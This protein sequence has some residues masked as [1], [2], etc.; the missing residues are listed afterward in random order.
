MAYNN[1]Q[2]AHVWASGSKA[3]GK[4]NNGN[5]YFD[6][7]VLYSYGSH[8]AVGVRMND[9]QAV[10]N[11]DSYSISTSGMQSDA[12]NA[13]SHFATVYVP[14]L[15]DIARDLSYIANNG[16]KSSARQVA[17]VIAHIETHAAAMNVKAGS[18]RWQE[19]AA[20]DGEETRADRLLRFCGIPKARAA[21]A[22]K[23]GVAKASRDAKAS[24]A[25]QRKAA[26]AEAAEVGSMNAGE[27]DSWLQKR[28]HIRPFDGTYGDAST[29][30]R[31]G[32]ASKAVFRLQKVAK[33][34]GLSAARLG[35][36]KAHRAAVLAVLKAYAED[37]AGM[38]A[39]YHAQ[40]F[41]NWAARMAEAKDDAAKLAVWRS[42]GVHAS[43]YGVDTPERAQ[44][45]AFDTW[46]RTEANRVK[47][48]E[49]REARE[50]WQRGEGRARVSGPDGSALV[51]RSKDGDTLETSHGAEV[52]WDHA[53][54]AFR[55]IALC[56]AKGEGFQ[57]NGRTVR[58][59]HFK[60]DSIAP[61]GDMRAGC[62]RFA[63]EAMRALAEREGVLALSPSDEAV[64]VS[65]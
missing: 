60:V 27:F 10:L 34:E 30:E 17:A 12:S 51:R 63:W 57:T 8:F 42:N 9:N 53:V 28:F 5:F 11:S 31:Y 49:E 6:A 43:A 33:A 61:N 36:L 1:S 40:R 46:G 25:K 19:E 59:G 62:H 44:L 47:Y 65:H 21:A 41:Q 32:E 56:V 13:V 2:V 45:E 26:K 54:K 35:R 16:A 20:S 14:K 3:N 24:A 58:V 4:S 37:S 39:E 48:E 29:A 7:R 52:P 18:Y 50:A 38:I 55:F 15:T 23:R 22:I 64:T